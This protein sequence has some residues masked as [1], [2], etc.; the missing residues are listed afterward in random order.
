MG[1]QLQTGSNS[2]EELYGPNAITSDLDDIEVSTSSGGTH[3]TIKNDD[4]NDEVVGGDGQDNKNTEPDSDSSDDHTDSTPQEDGKETPD[5]DSEKGPGVER[6]EL[7]ETINNLGEDLKG[8]G[9]DF[10]KALSELE[11]NGKLS[12]E[13]YSK[14][15]EAGYPKAVIDGYIKAAEI[16]ERNF[17]TAVYNLAGNK[18]E[19]T[20]VIE[21]AF[22]N[23]SKSEQKAYDDALERGDLQTAKLYVDSFMNRMRNV[24]GKG[25][26]R[27]PGAPAPSVTVE[28]FETKKDLT[29]ATSDPR[30]GRDAK[31]TKEIQN[32]IIK[33]T[34]L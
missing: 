15:S 21:W 32:R 27:V 24:R 10:D 19:Y 12:E 28:G 1:V 6:E 4:D 16:V 25:N 17:E 8:K 13:T 5:G 20:K 9:F 26:V 2:N 18:E 11:T 29:K 3:V 22:N 33:T 23:A 31:Y 30:Y 34:W 7:K 14:L